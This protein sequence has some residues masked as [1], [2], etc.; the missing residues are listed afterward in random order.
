MII[1]IE[2]VSCLRAGSY[3]RMTQG[4]VD[5][6]PDTIADVSDNTTIAVCQ[7]SVF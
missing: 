4:M 5:Q 6:A 1:L 7:L 3:Q 2:A